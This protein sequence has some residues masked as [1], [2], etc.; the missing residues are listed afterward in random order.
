M[1]REM[2]VQRGAAARPVYHSIVD[3]GLQMRQEDITRFLNEWEAK[4]CAAGTLERYHHSLNRLYQAL[5]EDK[6]IRRGTLA[7][8]R[9]DLRE[10]G[11]S[12]NTINTVFS[13]CN[14]W[15]DFMGHREYQLADQLEQE[16]K[17]QPELSRNEY[18]RLLQTAKLLDKEREYLLIKVF[19]STGIQVQE[20]PNVTV[21]AA[22]AGKLTTSAGNATETV[23]LAECLCKELLDYAGRKG[24]LTGPIFVTRNG[25]PII[26]TNITASICQVGIAAQI[27]KEKATPRCLRKLYQT[28][29][30]NVEANIALL[31]EQA[32]DQQIEL[33]QLTV[34]WGTER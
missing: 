23:H 20:L 7:K 31:V 19:A 14:S 26:R 25:T 8:W 4:G 5:P 15:L 12:P 10:E 30:A 16:D 11:Y 6:R 17:P 32:M 33:E 21:E 27:P 3:A 13:V 24:I 34:G 2:I 22:R 18:L 9:E 29:K 28:T 1:P